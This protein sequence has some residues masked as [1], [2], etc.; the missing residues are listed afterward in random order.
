MKIVL[1][2]SFLLAFVVGCAATERIETSSKD[3]SWSPPPDLA[4]SLV[5]SSWTFVN[6]MTSNDSTRQKEALQECL[7][8]KADLDVLFNESS[9]QVWARLEPAAK[10]LLDHLEKGSADFSRASAIQKFEAFSIRDGIDSRFAPVLKMIPKEIPA[11]RMVTHLK[12]R[13]FDSSTYFFV[14][15]RWIWIQG[16]EEIPSLLRKDQ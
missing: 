11:Y 8:D 6:E 7:P 5:Q 16:L 3:T 1:T 14:N 9:P 4:E 10:R 13:M 2:L 12:G 15:E